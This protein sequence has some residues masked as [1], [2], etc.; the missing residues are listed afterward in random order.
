VGKLRGVGSG[1]DCGGLRVGFRELCEFPTNLLLPDYARQ[2]LQ[3]LA[4]RK[5][6]RAQRTAP[7]RAVAL[8]GRLVEAR[9]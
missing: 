7:E 1:F 4:R 5:E 2:P 3:Q 8:A 9:R 6:Q